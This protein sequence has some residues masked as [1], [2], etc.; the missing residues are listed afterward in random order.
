VAPGVEAAALPE[1]TVSVPA[2]PVL[3]AE[4]VKVS[5]EATGEGE[6]HVFV[7]AGDAAVAHETRKLSEG[8]AE[9]T[10]PIPAEAQGAVAE[11]GAVVVGWQATRGRS[12]RRGEPRAC[13][14]SRRC[15]RPRRFGP[16]LSC[17]VTRF[18]FTGVTGRSPLSVGVF[19]ILLSTSIPSMTRPNTGCL[20]GPG[21]NQSR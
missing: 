19:S 9:I 6:V 2:P 3:T 11:G 15:A 13:R 20:E 12:R 7:G 17:T 18:I 5:L 21:V 16:Q 1:E 10:L 8:S 4:G 14:G